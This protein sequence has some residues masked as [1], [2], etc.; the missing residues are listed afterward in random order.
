MNETKIVIDLTGPAVIFATIAGPLL[1][2]WA[3]EWRY[4]RR[5]ARD[6]RK[7]VFQT[8]MSTRATRLNIVHVEALNQIDFVFDGNKYS[9]IREAW[10]IYRKHLKSP[11]SVSTGENLAIW[12]SK[13]TDLFETLLHEIS[14]GLN[15]PFEKSYIIENSYRPD[16][17]LFA[18]LDSIKI[19]RLLL[20][21]LEKGRPL[22]IRAIN[23]QEKENNSHN[24]SHETG[25][26]NS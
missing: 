7:Q 13:A 18:E 11:E 8:L 15:L 17:H 10:A 22:N 9:Q 2:V 20:E 1:A 4:S 14:K 12:Q 6:N 5:Q 21:V 3:S 25:E 19:R 24:Q 26:Q 16:A 23:E